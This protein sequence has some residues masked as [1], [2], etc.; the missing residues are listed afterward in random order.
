MAC[1]GVYFALNDDDEERLLAQNDDSRVVEI[2]TEEIEERWEAE[3]LCEVDKS[4]DAIHR[5]LGD[6][7]LKTRQTSVLSKA[8]IGGRQLH[9]GADWIISYL[10]AREVRDVSDAL[11]AIGEEEFRRR[12]FGLK[13]KFL[14]FDR[15][16]YDGEIGEQDFEYSWSYLEEIKKFFATASRAGRSVIFAVDQ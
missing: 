3:W 8:V 11:A 7:S 1:R 5:C 15:T 4:W 12:Y 13:K 14:W 16:D 2:I 9:R 6:G 10:S